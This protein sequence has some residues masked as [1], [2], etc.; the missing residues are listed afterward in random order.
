[1][2]P[3]LTYKGLWTQ[4]FFCYNPP[5]CIQYC[6]KFRETVSLNINLI[7]RPPGMGRSERLDP[8][9]V[10]RK[11]RCR[12]FVTRKLKSGHLYRSIKVWRDVTVF[13]HLCNC[14]FLK[15]KLILLAS[16]SLF[17]VFFIAHIVLYILLYVLTNNFLSQNF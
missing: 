2:K 15:L 11:Y 17:T 8:I 12:F 1:V 9:Q 4:I 13:S 6:R 14:N 10:K 3:N 7:F 16:L 5:Y